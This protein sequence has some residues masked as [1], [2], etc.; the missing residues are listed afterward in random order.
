MASQDNHDDIEIPSVELQIVEVEQEAPKQNDDIIAAY[1]V[2]NQRCD[3]LLSR[4]AS[5]KNKPS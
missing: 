4:I 2:L 5:R 1:I 3:E